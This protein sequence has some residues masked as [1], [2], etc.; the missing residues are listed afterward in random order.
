[1]VGIVQEL[2]LFKQYGA[3]EI[4]AA[5]AAGQFDKIGGSL[6]KLEW[7]DLQLAQLAGAEA[8]QE[9]SAADMI[10]AQVLSKINPAGDVIIAA[11][12][13]CIATLSEGA[14]DD[15]VLE[16]AV[17]DAFDAG[18]EVAAGKCTEDEVKFIASYAVFS[19]ACAL[20][21]AVNAFSSKAKLGNTE[22]I[23]AASAS[24]N[25]VFVSAFGPAFFASKNAYIADR[26]THPKEQ[27]KALEMGLEALIAN[28]GNEA[29]DPSPEIAETEAVG[30]ARAAFDQEMK[31]MLAGDEDNDEASLAE[32]EEGCL[33]TA[34]RVYKA[35]LGKE[36][37]ANV[38]TMM[39]MWKSAQRID[40]IVTN[41]VEGLNVELERVTKIKEAAQD[42]EGDARQADREAGGRPGYD[43]RI[44]FGLRTGETISASRN[45]V[46][47]FHEFIERHELRLVSVFRQIDTENLGFVQ[48]EVLLD[49]IEKMGLVI[50][51]RQREE[52]AKI[53][54][55]A[56]QEEDVV[57]NYSKFV[58][59]IYS[60]DAFTY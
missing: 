18:I 32:D 2:L 60:E 17:E 27:K 40:A 22:S 3:E 10:P 4:K 45:P 20:P 5:N 7:C 56:A 24:A 38:D 9:K 28:G 42:A 52:L 37:R 25:A 30:F 50:T 26:L 1:M 55:P 53:I 6:A 59:R 23:E 14:I 12:R 36:N 34:H 8:V 46:E 13:A 39:K 29:F 19:G 43:M 31:Q 54:S 21:A 35:A 11:R 47:L 41:F 33:S 44:D 58:E 57:I 48:L 51:P 49:G 15:D 16:D